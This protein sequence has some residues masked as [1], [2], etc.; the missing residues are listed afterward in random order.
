MPKFSSHLVA[1]ESATA[2]ACS[3]VPGSSVWHCMFCVASGFVHVMYMSFCCFLMSFHWWNFLSLS[4]GDVLRISSVA[5]LWG[6]VPETR[7]TQWSCEGLYVNHSTP[8]DVNLNHPPHHVTPCLLSIHGSCSWVAKCCTF[9][10]LCVSSPSLVM[11]QKHFP[12]FVFS[13][14][15]T[16]L[17]FM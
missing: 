7:T 13:L 1:A 17:A 2:P 11:V 5:H 15:S 3:V 12:T 16:Y 14:L 9:Y 6:L 10:S 4:R 8:M